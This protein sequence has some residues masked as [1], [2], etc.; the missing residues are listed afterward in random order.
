[1]S[2]FAVRLL[3]FGSF[4]ALG[5]AAAAPGAPAQPAPPEPP[6]PGGGDP[7]PL[8]EAERWTSA[9]FQVDDDSPIHDDVVHAAAAWS[10]ATGR[11]IT[12]S[13]DGDTPFFL[14][15]AFDAGCNAGPQTRGCSRVVADPRDSFT[16]IL[17]SLH[18][19]IRY[20]TILHEMGHHLRGNLDHVTSNPDAVLA[21]VRKLSS[22]TLTADDIAFVCSGPRFSCATAA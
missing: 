4:I 17:S 8:P 2:P 3:L 12:V 16:Q 13:A 20:G 10:A 14:V 15:D 6:D 5:C 9:S 1:V 18:W 21:P 22:D 7:E 19:S 11:T